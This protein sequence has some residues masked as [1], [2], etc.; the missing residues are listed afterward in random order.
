MVIRG[1][2]GKRVAYVLEVYPVISQ[3]FILREMLHFEA[4]GYLLTVFAVGRPLQSEL[5]HPESGQLTARIVYLRI[6]GSVTVAIKSIISHLYC[7]LY[8]PIRYVKTLAFVLSRRN[9]L[10]M[11]FLHAGQVAAGVRRNGIDHIHAHFAGEASSVAMLASMLTGRPYSFTVH[12][13]DVFVTPEF[14]NEKVVSAL[15]VIATSE[16]CAKYLFALCSLPV[17]EFSAKVH[18]IY[19]GIPVQEFDKLREQKVALSSDESPILL[20][21][22]RLV[23][24]KGH[25]YLLDALSV[26]GSRGIS[27]HWTI[28]GEGPERDSLT[29]RAAELDLS[30]RIRFVG[31]A[32]STHVKSLLAEADLFVLP[33]IKDSEGDMDGMPVALMEAMAAGVPVIST[34]I[35][36]IAELISDRVNGLLVEPENAD[37]LADAIESLVK[38]QDLCQRLVASARMR[39]REACDLAAI[40]REMADVFLLD[41]GHRG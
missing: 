31:A 28:V 11:R 8:D 16:Y 38:D 41:Q 34:P 15:S 39:V 32:D 36:G 33:C 22:A 35:S 2:A 4:M 20:T 19:L 9:V 10:L 26:L 37:A 29:E 14:V 23:P 24:K 21:V 12:A 3:L 40:V 18:V 1:N 5:S 17:E 30:D 6:G 25:K 13:R 7:L 27:A